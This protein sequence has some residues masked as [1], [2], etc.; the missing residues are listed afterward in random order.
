MDKLRVM[1]GR[2]H[3]QREIAYELGCYAVPILLQVLP[4]H[5]VL[6]IMGAI[7][8]EHKVTHASAIATSMRSTIACSPPCHHHT[9]QVVIEA[10]AAVNLETLSSVTLAMVQ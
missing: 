4:L 8:T 1:G 7:M 6:Q 5:S 2:S 3:A 9:V 10:G